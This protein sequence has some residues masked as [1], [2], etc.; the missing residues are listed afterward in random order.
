MSL[1]INFTQQFYIVGKQV[2]EKHYA[3]M[4]LKQYLSAKYCIKGK[5][6]MHW[7]ARDE[8]FKCVTYQIFSDINTCTYK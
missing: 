5:K 2:R 4:P 6:L 3:N 7:P 8:M 1:L